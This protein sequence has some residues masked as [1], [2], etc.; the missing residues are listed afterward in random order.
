MT[1][2][3]R[4]CLFVRLPLECD[5]LLAHPAPS[6]DDRIQTRTFFGLRSLDRR[7]PK[8]AAHPGCAESRCP[9]ETQRD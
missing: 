2:T 8:A 6:G 1:R 4:G 5:G 3:E 7:N 9:H